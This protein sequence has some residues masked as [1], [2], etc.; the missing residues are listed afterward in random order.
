MGPDPS[1]L[2]AVRRFPYPYRAMLAICSDLDETPNR[3]VY[4]ETARYLNTTQPTSMGLGVGLEVGNTMYFDMPPDQFAYWNT[5][6]AGRDMVR[7]LMRS[8]HIDCL[9]S[10]GDL[11]VMRKD[12][13][14]ALNELARHDCRIQVWIDHGTAP[15]NFGADIM[16]GRGDLP[17][18]DVFHA[19]LTY[20]YGVRYVWRGRVT[21]VIGQDVPR[22]LAGIWASGHPVASSKTMAKEFAK[23]LLA[24]GGSLKYQM[25]TANRV[26]QDVGLRSGHR[27]WEFLRANPHWGGVSC[28][29]T[30]D[31][32]AEVLVDPMLERLVARGGFLILYT[33]LGKIHDQ[34]EPL[35]SP[36]RAAL[37]RLVRYVREGRIL[38]TTTRR[39][40]TYCR[41]LHGARVTATPSDDG[42]LVEVTTGEG[43]AP[44]EVQGLCLYVPDPRRTRLTVNRQERRDVV[45]NPPDETGRASLSVGW[46]PLT[47]PTGALS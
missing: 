20:D 37:H 27:V 21:S 38:V 11:A 43:D 44:D 30:A 4:W 40:L 22:R 35:R 8:G 13:D 31:G 32:L 41:A 7:T 5:D 17:G 46:K 16:Q 6:D 3:R 2:V 45:S 47:F 26:F 28:G 36:T 19:D 12:A 25:H 18:A 10:F 42:L 15:S 39:L 24:R 14:R 1:S 23:G 29:E 9:H 34:N 33:H